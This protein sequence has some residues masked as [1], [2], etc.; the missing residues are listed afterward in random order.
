MAGSYLPVVI[1]PSVSAGVTG[2]NNYQPAT[3]NIATFYGEYTLMNFGL[4]HAQI[5]NALSYVNLGKADFQKELYLAKLQICQLYFGL[6]QNQYRL[7]VDSQNIDRYQNI[8][9]V[10][11]ALTLSGIKPWGRFF[12]GKSRIIIRESE[13]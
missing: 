1:V 13:L 2:A 5:N 3:G 6:L 11:R 10:I 4:H 7:N 12:I 9:N 8:F